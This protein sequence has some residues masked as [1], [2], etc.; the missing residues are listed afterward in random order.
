MYSLSDVTFQNFPHLTT[1]F[2]DLILLNF[3][4]VSTKGCGVIRSLKI[5]YSLEAE[6]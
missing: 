6:S 1:K 4:T 3:R 2:C 5:L